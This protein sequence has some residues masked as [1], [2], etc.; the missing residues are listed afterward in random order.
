M[1]S[2]KKKINVMFVGPYPPP[3]G[4][5]SSLILSLI[6]GY[7]EKQIKKAIVVYFDK[8]DSIEFLER[9]TVYRFSVKKNLIKILNPRNI[10]ILFSA[11]NV[12]KGKNLT[13][14]DFIVTIVKTILINNIAEEENINVVSFYQSDFSLPLL[15]CKKIWHKNRGIVLTVFGEIFDMYS[16]FLPRKELFVELIES[17]DVVISSSCYCSLAYDQI[18][19][20]RKIEVI[21]V[22]VSLDRFNNLSRD[23]EREKYGFL[24]SDTVLLYMGRFLNEM[25]LDSILKIAPELIKFDNS[26]KL[27]LAGAK[28]QLTEEALNLRV[29]YPDNIYVMNDITFDAQPS[30]YAVSDIVLAPTK[31]K[32]ACMGVTIKEA[33]AASKPVIASDSGGIPEAT[34]N[35]KTGIIVPLKEDGD[36]DLDGFISAILA[37]YQ[38]KEKQKEFGI[39]SRER[40]KQL[41]SEDVTNEK[42]LD[43]FKRSIQKQ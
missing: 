18:G 9:A 4:G 33:M 12:Y 2:E 14:R 17:A 8:K 21:Y 32:H 7:D 29:K 11:F 22:G 39:S 35:D 5:I 6:E 43:A 16:Y 24:P 3:F 40:V 10:L 31:D 13:L 20:K 37:L 36:N 1:E 26:I 28:G 34:I 19:N 23:T 41:F 42:Y 30:L 25:G 27:L 38:D 15:L